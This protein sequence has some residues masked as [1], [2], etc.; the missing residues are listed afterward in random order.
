MCANIQHASSDSWILQLNSCTHCNCVA[1]HQCVLTYVSLR[2]KKVCTNSCKLC[3][4][5]NVSSELKQVC[6][7]SY[8]WCT[9]MASQYCESSNDFLDFYYLKDYLNDCNIGIYVAYQWI[10]LIAMSLQ[11]CKTWDI[12]HMYV[13][14]PLSG[15]VGDPSG[16][17]CE[18]L[19]VH[20]MCT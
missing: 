15:C 4:W 7:N 6:T 16:D 9:G 19:N 17:A 3:T 20:I 2:L 13:G 11:T 14:F 8:R 1:F 18:L 5:I 12:D 10:A